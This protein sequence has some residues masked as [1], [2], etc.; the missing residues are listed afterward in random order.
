MKARGQDL[1]WELSRNQRG[2]AKFRQLSEHFQRLHFQPLWLTHQF[3]NKTCGEQNVPH[4]A[5]SKTPKCADDNFKKKSAT[6]PREDC[7]ETAK[8][9]NLWL[10][11]SSWIHVILAVP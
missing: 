5:K 10:R 9:H 1:Q 2:F 3:N 7:G 4:Y 8:L 11:D 6:N